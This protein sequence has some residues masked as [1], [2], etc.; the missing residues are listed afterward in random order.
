MRRALAAASFACARRRG[1][2]AHH[3]PSSSF[4]FTCS[5]LLV[6]RRTL[7]VWILAGE[8][9]GDVLAGGFLAALRTEAAARGD[10]VRAVAG[11]GGPA[12][13]AAGLPSSLFPMEDLS[14][15]GAWE[16]ASRLPLL[17]RRLKEATSRAREFQPDVLI[18]VDAKGFAR[19]LIRG[20]VGD[21]GGEVNALRAPLAAQYVSPSWWAWR[22]GEAGL[23]GWRDAGLDLALCLLPWETSAWRRVGVDAAFVGHPVVTDVAEATRVG[24]KTDGRATARTPSTLAILPGSRA[25][26]VK[27]HLPL[28]RETC[29]AMARAGAAPGSVAFL[30]P[31]SA[32]SVA[33]T[34]ARAAETWPTS[35]SAMST[36]TANDPASRAVFFQRA[37]AALTCAGT[38]TAQLLAHGVPQVIAYRAHPVTETLARW[39]ARVP[40]A[41]LPN[42]VT[43][44]DVAPEFLGR[45]AATPEALAEAMVRVLT[46]ER[47]REAQRRE[48]EGFLDALAPRDEEGRAM[49]PA[50]AAARAVLDALLQ[51][52]ARE[53]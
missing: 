2:G 30:I 20:V 16:M 23:R 35:A 12:T 25:Q 17:R 36:T 26:E 28:F 49:E 7:R 11:V 41:G 52:R 3:D 50:A 48:R 9:S 32:P 8:P 47:A 51:K 43:G 33:E 19:R 1:G 38:A 46:D 14:A 15:M 6:S 22:D 27:R 4:P 5:S 42:L 24:I 10:P 39:M 18:T 40:H 34:V 45:R 21:R 44:R 29:E 37:D 53:R 31:G 13:I